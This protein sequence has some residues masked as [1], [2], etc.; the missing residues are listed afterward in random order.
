MLVGNEAGCKHA[1]NRCILISFITG[2]IASFIFFT[3]DNFIINY[4]IHDKI[5]KN[6]IYLICIAL[7]FIAMSSAI[8]GYFIG[9]RRV[10]KNILA[11][12]LEEFIKIFSSILLLNILFSSKLE[13]A[14]YSLILGDVISEVLSFVY[15]LFLFNKDKHPSSLHRFKD[16]ETYDKRILKISIP[17]AFTSYLRSGLSTLEQILVPTSLEKSG[18]SCSES[19]SKYGLIGGMTLPIIMF[20]S[21]FINSFAGLLVPEFSRYYIKND[22]KKI[23]NVTKIILTLTTFFSILLALV[24]YFFS[25]KICI[26]LF[27]NT[28]IIKYVRILCPLILFICLDIVIDSIL[29]GLNAQISVMLINI[30]DCII[31]ILF[32][33]FIVPLYGLYGFIFSIIISELLN[34]SLSS[35]KLYKILK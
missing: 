4:C 14:C 9:V 25:P 7:P 11:K 19:L 33:Y 21:I 18:F 2:I 26:L 34:F 5:S 28:E 16:L 12:F 10:H 23:K 8:N 24:F 31:S 6:I 15:L 29:K 17:V 3:F 20:S 13:E 32:I 22:F 30:I 35:W 27:K 1:T